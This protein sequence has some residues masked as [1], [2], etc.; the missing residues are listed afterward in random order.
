MQGIIAAVPTPVDARGIPSEPLFLEHARWALAN[1]CDGLNVLGSTGEANSLDNATR[2]MVM[3]WAADGLDPSRL[4][5]G[6]GTPSLAETI[7]LTVHAEAL[8]YPVALV[9]PPYY[10]TPPSEQG[11]LRWYS[12]LHEALGNRRIQIWFYNYPQM[13]GFV[14][15]EQVIA[16]L[17]RLA[18]ER[19]AGIKDSSG[20]LDYCRRLARTL[21]A[22]RVFPSSETTLSM[23]QEAGFAGCISATV[24]HS[25]HLCSQVW[26]G[27][28][29]PA[30]YSDIA[31][32]RTAISSQPLIPSI[33]HLIARRTGDATWTHTLPPFLPL[34]TGEAVALDHLVPDALTSAT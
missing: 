12:A 4:M 20:D 32:L 7:A 34:S 27:N 29:S 1:G 3:S 6:T 13:T 28:A 21:L 9:L 25:A 18:P 10:Y 31:D 23:A 14:I 26:R 24:N 17:H 19:F 30:A 15:P 11:L 33:K 16:Q 22:L 5:V 8:G 2:R